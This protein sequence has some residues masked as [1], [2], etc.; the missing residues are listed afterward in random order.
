MGV[1]ITIL[2]QARVSDFVLF[3][4]NGITVRWL[5]FVNAGGAR[6]QY[7]KNNCRAVKAMIRNGPK[8]NAWV[9]FRFVNSRK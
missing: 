9:E 3:F 5:F 7:F 2:K 1:T 4:K 6:A 8:A